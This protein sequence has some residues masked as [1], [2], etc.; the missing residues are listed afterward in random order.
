M[1]VVAAIIASA[2]SVSSICSESALYQ[3]LS[4]PYAS[5]S[6]AQ[7]LMLASAYA[8]AAGYNA[9]YMGE[10]GEALRIDGFSVTDRNS[11]MVAY[12]VCCNLYAVIGHGS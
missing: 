10:L 4:A 12:R 2:V 5:Y 8:K 6:A 1:L 3:G 7:G 11:A 9:S